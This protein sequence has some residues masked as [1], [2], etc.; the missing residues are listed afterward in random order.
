M[1]TYVLIGSYIFL[2]LQVIAQQEKNKEAFAFTITGYMVP[3]SDSIIVVQVQIPAG[4]KVIIEKEQMGLARHNYSNGN[5]DTTA[6][7][8]G[9][10]KL[11]KGEYY[12]YSLHLYDTQKKPQKNDLLYTYTVYPAT[13]KGR[14][15]GLVKNAV[16]FEH[17]TG[18]SFFDFNTPA[19]LNEQ[20]E[21]SLIDSLV[22]DIKFTG[23]EMLKQDN[24]QNMDITSG[25]F[26]GKKLFAA[27]QMVTNNNVKDF[28]DY[29]LA[30]PQKYAGNT[31]KIAETF[32][33]WMTNNTPTVKP[34]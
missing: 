25:I 32:A 13:Y 4:S 8:W 12:Y 20:S 3:A 11:I 10:C 1:K 5:Y 9:R 15:Y 31:W 18:G 6:I 22:T 26:A 28:L 24:G 33:T 21:N 17:V 14:F 16:Y 7:G 29:V 2:S 19:I 34:N 23:R 27:M 30:R